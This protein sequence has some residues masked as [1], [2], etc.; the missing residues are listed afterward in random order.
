MTQNTK[1]FVETQYYTFGESPNEITLKSG[2][3]LGPITLAYETYGEL[4]T[5]KSNAIIIFHA[6]TGDA[7]VAGWHQG[8]KKPGWWDEMIGPNKAF[9]TTDH[10]II[11]VNAIGSCKGSSGP[12]SINPKINK[13]YGLSFPVV[14]IED[15]VVS[16]KKL[17][18]HLG[19]KKLFCCA[20]GSMG[21]LLALKWSVLYPE[22][23][24]S[25]II[26]ACNYR[27]TAQQI[28][29]H[30]V[31]RQAIMS[32]PDWQ[33][34]DYYGKS[35]PAN[36]MAVSRMI[37]HIT[38]MSE[39]SMEERFGRKLIKKEKLGYDFSNDFEV[40]SYLN[41]RGTSFVQRFDANSYLYLSKALDY[42]DLSEDGNLI[43]LFKHTD[44]NFLIISFTS[45]WLYPSYQSKELVK[46]LK[47]NDIDISSIEIKTSYG[48]DSFLIEIDGQS[49]LIKN[50]LNKVKEEK[51]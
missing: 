36:G 11:C 21:G 18:D 17:I 46:A 4:N 5:D 22:N 6:L 32:D 37:G 27:H 44:A 20:G 35:I 23:V 16:Q 39:A 26:I 9:N 49:K 24:S 25:V 31:A 38:Y 1:N 40:E 3:K 7:H 29:L 48:H 34:G 51:Y 19:I 43:E 50:F 28:A 13:P 42:F 15:M 8:D 14:T 41:Y 47:T 45:D 12:S 2:E 30:E 33:K 10:F